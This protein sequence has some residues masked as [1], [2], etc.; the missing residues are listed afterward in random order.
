MSGHWEGIIREDDQM[1]IV[2]QILYAHDGLAGR[3]LNAIDA[4]ES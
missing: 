2:H 1:V 4:L 3:C